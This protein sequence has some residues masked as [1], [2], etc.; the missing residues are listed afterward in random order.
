MKMADDDDAIKALMELWTGGQV[1]GSN[2]I[3]LE[4]VLA[5]QAWHNLPD[6]VVPV[7]HQMLGVAA[8]AY[9]QEE[10]RADVE[11]GVR[12]KE[13]KKLKRAASILHQGLGELHPDLSSAFAE[14]EL[15]KTV[16]LGLN[17]EL[18]NGLTQKVMDPASAEPSGE[19]NT[20]IEPNSIT[21]L[22]SQ[23]EQFI[24]LSESTLKY[25]GEGQNGPRSDEAVFDLMRLCNLIW[26]EMLGREF[27]LAWY[28]DDHGFTH[29]DSDAAR[30]CVDLAGAVD[31][32]ISIS[33]VVSASRKAREKPFGINDLGSLLAEA[34]ELRIRMD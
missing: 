18:I 19:N 13:L 28:T 11:A 29:G 14:T 25:L 7:L 15:I 12:R 31:M 9:A 32:Q 2:L 8:L 33:R 23:L 34:D 21:S 20:Q 27:K 3:E 26:T 10:R 16:A 30:F 24:K 17:Q 6:E 1:I 22:R 4:Q 5:L